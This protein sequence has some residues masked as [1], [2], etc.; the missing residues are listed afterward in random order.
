MSRLS[1]SRVGESRASSLADY[2]LQR[3]DS[4]LRAPTGIIQHP[5]LNPGGSYL[6]QLWD[7]DSYWVA[8][9]LWNLAKRRGDSALAEAVLRHS[10]GCLLNFFEHQAPNGSFPILISP[11]NPDVFNCAAAGSFPANPAKPLFAQFAELVC[12]MAGDYSWLEPYWEGLEAFYLCWENRYLTPTGL[13]VWGSDVAI[14]VDNDPTTYGRP[15][16]SSA[17]ILLNC[18]LYRDFKAAGRLA[19]ALGRDETAAGYADRAR[20]IADYI[21]GMTDRYAIKE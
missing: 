20:V 8:R 9:G 13:Y 1:A 2:F 16:Y 5:F 3:H 15:F 19:K 10:Q 12:E 17:N 18:F 14:G 6:D 11:D 21:A 7:W 4:L